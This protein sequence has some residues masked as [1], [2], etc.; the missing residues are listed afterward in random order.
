MGRAPL[1]GTVSRAMRLKDSS[2]RWA[3]GKDNTSPTASCHKRIIRLPCSN[4]THMTHTYTPN[5][6]LIE[7]IAIIST[8][9]EMKGQSS[10][11]R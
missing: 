10:T 4:Y 1:Q 9:M 5:A 2:R 7:N 8:M 3:K 6:L 11:G